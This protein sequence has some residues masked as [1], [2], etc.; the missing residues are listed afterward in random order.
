MSSSTPG[1]PTHFVTPRGELVL[2]L[3]IDRIFEEALRAPVRTQFRYTPA[4][5]LV[6][7]VVFRVETGPNVTWRIG[8]DVLGQG[9]STP[10][11]VGDVQVWPAHLELRRSA[12][13]RISSRGR[14]ALFELPVLP[15]ERWLEE[16]YGLVPAGTETHGL[17]W[18]AFAAGL[19]Q[20][21]EVPPR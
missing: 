18:D 3:T 7:T 8:R 12:R 9:M 14:T 21:P 5:P 4:D 13:L 10:S 1:A 19:L 17:D 6:V 20:D 2:P 15:L 11:G 16:T